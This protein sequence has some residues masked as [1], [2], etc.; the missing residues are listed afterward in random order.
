MRR[1]VR[2]CVGLLAVGCW[3]LCSLQLRVQRA[4]SVLPPPA[5]PALVAKKCADI[6][7]DASATCLEQARQAPPL[8][9]LAIPSPF[10]RPA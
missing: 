6:P 5:H 2:V 4:A 3:L 10:R 7:P 8:P 1:L 9:L